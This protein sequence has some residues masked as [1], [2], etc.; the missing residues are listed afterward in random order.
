MM[1]LGEEEGAS[2]KE[3]PEKEMAE[4]GGYGAGRLR[5]NGALIDRMQTNCITP[6]CCGVTPLT[7]KSAQSS[8]PK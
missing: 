5:K 6:G 7:E 4:H 2:D 1:G 8:S 3:Q